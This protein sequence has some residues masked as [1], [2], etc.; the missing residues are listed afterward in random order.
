MTLPVRPFSL[1]CRT[2]LI[3]SSPETDTWAKTNPIVDHLGPLV[4]FPPID[5]SSTRR[6]TLH[7]ARIKLGLTSSDHGRDDEAQGGE[8]QLPCG[9]VKGQHGVRVKSNRPTHEKLN[10]CGTALNCCRSRRTGRGSGLDES[11]YERG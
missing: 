11:D 3:S 7:R 2:D 5:Q 1:T 4:R 6:C 10:D 8:L 9:A